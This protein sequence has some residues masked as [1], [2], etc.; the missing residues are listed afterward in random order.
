MPFSNMDS[1]SFR[2][3]SMTMN[4]TFNPYSGSRLVRVIA[5]NCFIPSLQWLQ[6]ELRSQVTAFSRSLVITLDNISVVRGKSI[7]GVFLSFVTAK[8]EAINCYVSMVHMDESMNGCNLASSIEIMLTEVFSIPRHCKATSDNV[9]CAKSLGIPFI[10]C[11]SAD[12]DDMVNFSLG[13]KRTSPDTSLPVETALMKATHIMNIVRRS[14]SV[15]RAFRALGGDWTVHSK[16]NMGAGTTSVWQKTLANVKSVTDSTAAFV[17]LFR[18]VSMT[19]DMSMNMNMDGNNSNDIPVPPPPLD[20]T[21]T[22]LQLLRHQTPTFTDWTVWST[23]VNALSPLQLQAMF[24]GGSPPPPFSCV[25]YLMDLL[26]YSCESTDIMSQEGTAEGFQSV[27]DVRRLVT[28]CLKS[29]FLG[30]E[31]KSERRA[32]YDC[33]CKATLLDPRTKDFT[34]FLS[35]GLGSGPVPGGEGLLD[36]RR[37]SVASHG[38]FEDAINLVLSEMMFDLND[39]VSMDERGEFSMGTQR[40]ALLNVIRSIRFSTNRAVEHHL[41]K[42]TVNIP[43]E[44]M[45][46]YGGSG[47]FVGQKRK[48]NLPSEAQLSN[49]N[50]NNP[51]AMDPE[52][53]RR[54]RIE[55]TCKEELGRYCA[56]ES[57]CTAADI[58]KTDS[59]Q[60]WARYEETYPI[61][62]QLARRY[63]ALRGM[64]SS[65]EKLQKIVAALHDRDRRC[66]SPGL[67]DAIV[68]LYVNGTLDTSTPDDLMNSGAN[69]N[70]SSPRMTVLQTNLR[71]YLVEPLL[72][73]TLVS[74]FVVK[75]IFMV[76]IWDLKAIIIGMDPDPVLKVSGI[77]LGLRDNNYD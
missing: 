74:V 64:A 5:Q 16:Q 11:M 10:S 36:K 15:L 25:L 62:S 4:P 21:E 27:L 9:T 30:N 69:S 8:W 41:M 48:A 35:S 39:M 19:T 76:V 75:I 63:S 46:E 73:W 44:G 47:D 33:M 31:M 29:F 37:R 51:N 56:C 45:S 40:P 43:L 14:P 70:L 22:D 28:S 67:V 59:L 52:E 55:A 20:M 42:M 26:V 6:K 18:R 23:L 66:I 72:K 54:R 1:V 13:L 53:D 2:S 58:P 3:Y 71:A 50:N 68:F 61:L 57:P 12:M 32:M 65:N 24:L 77:F 60:W 7:I 17:E 34:F 38:L 49:N